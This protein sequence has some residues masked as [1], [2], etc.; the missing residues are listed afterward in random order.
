M[1]DNNVTRMAR[2][3]QRRVTSATTIGMMNALKPN[4]AHTGLFAEDVGRQY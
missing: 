2:D 3:Q 4:Y 1:A